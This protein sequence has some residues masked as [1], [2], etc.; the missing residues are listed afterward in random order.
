MKRNRFTITMSLLLVLV[1]GTAGFTMF[2][3]TG[4]P[5]QP[6]PVTAQFVAGTDG[7]NLR[8]LKVATDGTL[9]VSAAT[10]PASPNGSPTVPVQGSTLFNSQATSG[11]NAAQ[12]FTFTG[13]AGFRSVLRAATGSISAAGSCTVTIQ[14]GA[15][16]IMTLPPLTSTTTVSLFPSGFAPSTGIS[17]STGNNLVVTIGACGAA[18]TSTVA[19]VGDRS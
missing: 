6:I 9:Q 15:T 11:A 13:A 10:A 17:A 16:T 5:G 12:T 1:L 14:D 3:S 7:T 19:V 4:Q 8:G 2:Q 18:V